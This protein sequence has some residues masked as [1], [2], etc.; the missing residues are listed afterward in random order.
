MMTRLA[1]LITWATGPFYAFL[2]QVPRWVWIVLLALLTGKY[3]YE[4]G[5]GEGKEIGR[6]KAEEEFEEAIQEANHE[7]ERRIESAEQ[8][9][10][11]IEETIFED[12]PVTADSLNAA[13][14]ER[15]RKHTKDDPH[16]A[17]RR[18]RDVEAD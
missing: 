16:N 5:R 2:K 1:P 18:M 4:K 10:A 12:E 9:Q 15:L 6:E 13:Q 17:G 3:L 8:A 7:T 14:L 11:E